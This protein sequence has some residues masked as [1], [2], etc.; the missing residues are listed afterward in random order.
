MTG[1][2]TGSE[3]STSNSRVVL[4]LPLSSSE[5]GVCLVGTLLR[6]VVYFKEDVNYTSTSLKLLG[7]TRA[8]IMGKERWQAGAVMNASL[9]GGAIGA[10]GMPITSIERLPF[11]ELDIPLVSST[12]AGSEGS[13]RPEKSEPSSSAASNAGSQAVYEF[14]LPYPPNDQLLPAV[15]PK[16]FDMTTV[17]VTWTL[18][19]TGVRKGLLKRNDSL[20]LDLPVMFPTPQVSL[21]TT[22]SSIHPF[23]F[24]SGANEGMTLQATLSATPIYHRS[25][26][27]F[28]LMLSPS[29]SA[30]AHLLA[31]SSPPLKVDA[32]LSRQTRTTPIANPNS[33]RSFEWAGVRILMAEMKRVK[34][35]DWKWEGTISLPDGECS[36]ESKGVAIS[37]KLNCH[38]VSPVLAQAALHISLPVFLPSTIFEASAPDRVEPSVDNLPAY[39]S[40]PLLASS[41][42]LQITREHSIKL[43]RPRHLN[44][45]NPT[46]FRS[47]SVF[48]LALMLS[49]LLISSQV[50]AQSAYNPSAS[51]PQAL[52]QQPVKISHGPRSGPVA[53]RDY[54]Y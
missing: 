8:T 10:A 32:S 26:I 1:P 15:A 4:S 42:R 27:H 38:I 37:H 40:L 17:S 39:Y 23:K 48:L 12:T 9:G 21:Q 5:R 43:Q 34:D 41:S 6:P 50:A 46:M 24:D 22:I 7:E 54:K 30:A 44:P 45:M 31:T 3:L 16:E 52:L 51:C 18:R 2:S 29:T 49:V 19:F 35:D 20:S 53:G 28:S 13:K 11:L 33:G 36:V 25:P 14:T 47:K